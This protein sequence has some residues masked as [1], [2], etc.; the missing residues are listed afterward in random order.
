VPNFHQTDH[1]QA[2]QKAASKRR[3]AGLGQTP[4]VIARRVEHAELRAVYSHQA[5]TAI[6]NT[7]DAD[8]PRPEV[9]KPTHNQL[10][11]Q[12]PPED[13]AVVGCTPN[14]SSKSRC[15]FLQFLATVAAFLQLMVDESADQPARHSSAGPLRGRGA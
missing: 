13:F 15:N 14:R 6:E 1:A 10:L 7:P 2:W 9:A 5:V 3:L 8:S 4:R 11:E 12:N